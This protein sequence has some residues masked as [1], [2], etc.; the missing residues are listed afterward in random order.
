MKSKKPFWSLLFSM[1]FLVP[2]LKNLPIF[3]LHTSIRR[4]SIICDI[5]EIIILLT[6]KKG[7]IDLWNKWWFY[8]VERVCCLYSCF[9]GRFLVIFTDLEIVVEVIHNFIIFYKNNYLKILK[10][11]NNII[12]NYY[13]PPFWPLFVFLLLGV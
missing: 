5:K 3:I 10:S 1:Q 8:L 12:K 7:K 13:L 6:C 2:G 11:V 4:H 9:S